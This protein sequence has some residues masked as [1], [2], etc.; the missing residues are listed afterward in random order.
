MRPDF[1]NLSPTQFDLPE[2]TIGSLKDALAEGDEAF[3]K[4]LADV[5][6]HKVSDEISDVLVKVL[7]HVIDAR[8]PAMR[9]DVIAAACGMHIRTGVSLTQMSKRHKVTRTAIAKEVH[10]VCDD[11]GLYYPYSNTNDKLLENWETAKQARIRT[12]F[13]IVRALSEIRMW[14]AKETSRT[15][16]EKWPTARRSFFKRDLAFAVKLAEKL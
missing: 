1:N 5:V 2:E 14:F 13:N 11:W 10:R 6:R 16:I 3:E 8:N 12:R 7:A 9:A 15:P 4:A